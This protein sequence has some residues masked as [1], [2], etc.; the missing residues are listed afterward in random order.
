MLELTVKSVIDSKY[1]FY[2]TC[3]HLTEGEKGKCLHRVYKTL[4]LK[5]D[6]RFIALFTPRLSRKQIFDI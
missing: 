3:M 4:R 1:C 2:S 5:I 6:Y